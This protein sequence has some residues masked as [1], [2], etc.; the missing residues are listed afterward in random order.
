[1]TDLGAGTDRVLEIGLGLAD[2][3]G[4]PAVGRV[5]EI[6]RPRALAPTAE[7]GRDKVLV[8]VPVGAARRSSA[9]H[10]VRVVV[11]KRSSVPHNVRAAAR[12]SA[13]SSATMPCSAADQVRLRVSSSRGRQSYS[14][15]GGGH[16]QAGGRSGGGGGRGG[17]GG[18]GRRSDI[19]LKHEITLLGH[20][21][22]GLGFYRFSYNG[23]D[24][25]YVGVMAQEVQAV[26]PE[27]VARGGDGYLTGLLRQARPDVRTYD[28]WIAAGGHVPAGNRS[29]A[30]RARTP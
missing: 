22:N 24:K 2:R 7:T 20:L 13:R 26:V 6:D 3:P 21:D 16:R 23:S 28:A 12:R 25:A 1:M 9:P 15:G 27:A 19:A 29:D 4:A 17:G 10:S 14:G 18:G 8:I 30:D 11:A 5:L